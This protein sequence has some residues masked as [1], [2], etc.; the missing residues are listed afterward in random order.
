MGH[1]NRNPLLTQV[2]CLIV[3]T[4]T[5]KSKSNIKNK[6]SKSRGN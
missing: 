4:L 2:K 3:C 5:I 1:D 6:T